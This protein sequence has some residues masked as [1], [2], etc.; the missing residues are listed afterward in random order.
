MS[1]FKLSIGSKEKTMQDYFRIDETLKEGKASFYIR[2]EV[3]IQALKDIYLSGCFSITTATQYSDVVILD[4][5]VT[6]SRFDLKTV[7]NSY[8]KSEDKL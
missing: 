6:K 8:L 1:D 7:L 4:N 3:K 5:K 2:K